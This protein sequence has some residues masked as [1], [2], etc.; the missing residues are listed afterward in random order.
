MNVVIRDI[1]EEPDIHNLI[2]MYHNCMALNLQNEYKSLILFEMYN[3]LYRFQLNQLEYLLSCM[4][5]NKYNIYDMLPTNEKDLL[6]FYVNHLIRFRKS[7]F[8]INELI[9]FN[10][11]IISI[12]CNEIVHHCFMLIDE[13]MSKLMNTGDLILTLNLYYSVDLNTISGV[14]YF[15][16]LA[17]FIAYNISY[18]TVENILYIFEYIQHKNAA[19]SYND[20]VYWCC[21]ILYRIKNTKSLQI[22]C[23]IYWSIRELSVGKALKCFLRMTAFEYFTKMCIEMDNREVLQNKH[24]QQMIKNKHRARYI[25]TCLRYLK[26]DCSLIEKQR[27]LLDYPKT[28]L[29]LREDVYIVQY[30]MD[31]IVYKE[32]VMGINDNL[33]FHDY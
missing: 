6:R 11:V 2:I 12:H 1:I 7:T 9:S 17:T 15:N 26:G 27:Y 31:F 10:D 22:L 16:E 23:S 8:T 19:V 14:Y 20:V 25:Y 4:N 32:N 30:Y 29:I 5:D 24:F 18:S 13:C 33:I 28:M 21:L 3:R